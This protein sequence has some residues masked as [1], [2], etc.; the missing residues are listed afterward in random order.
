MVN[1]DASAKPHGEDR[2]LRYVK[3]QSG[4]RN[5]LHFVPES[6]FDQDPSSSA[7]CRCRDAHNAI[8]CRISDQQSAD[9]CGIFCLL[10]KHHHMQ[11]KSN[12]Q[13]DRPRWEKGRHPWYSV[14]VRPGNASNPIVSITRWFTTLPRYTRGFA[15]RVT[16]LSGGER[17]RSIES[18]RWSGTMKYHQTTMVRT[19]IILLHVYR[20]WGSRSWVLL[21]SLAS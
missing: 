21:H 2:A 6:F 20:R 9:P 7:L 17:G 11:P 4:A 13:C 1:S 10:V 5:R 12:H 3:D 19:A 8:K 15:A 16:R 14:I 18:S